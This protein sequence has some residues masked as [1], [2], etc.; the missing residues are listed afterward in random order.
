MKYYYGIVEDRQ[1][2]LKIGRVRVRV[3]GIHTEKKGDIS[4]PDLPWAQVMLPTTSAGLSGFGT[5]HG[6][7]EGSTVILFFRDE[8]ECQQPVII[9]STAGIPSGGYIKNALGEKIQRNIEMG[10][11]D[12]RRL[13]V[14]DYKG[15]PDGENPTHSSKRGFGLTTALDTAP[16]IYDERHIN[17]LGKIASK[18]IEPTLT[19][20]DLPY[21][22]LYT[23]KT[24]VTT[25]AGTD[26][27]K[28]HA[29]RDMSIK[30]GVLFASGKGELKSPAN[31]V[32]PYNKVIQSESGHVIE[33]DD[34]PSA[35]RLAI[36]H[37]SG[38]FQEIHPDGSQVTRV[39]TDN[40]TVICRD[41]DVFIGGKVFIKVLGDANIQA[42]GNVDIKGANVK[43]N[44]STGDLNLEAGGNVILN[45]GTGVVVKSPHF[46]PDG[47]LPEVDE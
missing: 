47:I 46:S 35:E 38:T 30:D 33:M 25:L 45:G 9:G 8:I 40:Y 11:N 37:R 32:Y 27:K 3:H 19:K 26:A 4:T 6:L 42:G 34:T 22:P 21:Y 15:T 28:L 29:G 23:D 5:Q 24:D 36:E 44:A 31:P 43:V 18:I 13:S 7:V 16:K 14:G 20:D 12:P 41:E 17:Y 1:D 10:F 39:V 2:P